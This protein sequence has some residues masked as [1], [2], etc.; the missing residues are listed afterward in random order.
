MACLCMA[1]LGTGT[2]PAAPT[3]VPK[4]HTSSHVGLGHA[5][6]AGA[7]AAKRA[8]RL[9]HQPDGCHASLGCCDRLDRQPGRPAALVYVQRRGPGRRLLVCRPTC[10]PLKA[11]PSPPTRA[12]QRTRIPLDT[13]DRA[14]GARALAGR[15][16]AGPTLRTTHCAAGATGMLLQVIESDCGMPTAL[17][18][19]S[20]QY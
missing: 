9:R 14:R 18:L 15:G 3:T 1:W 20:V 11:P 10:R 12:L 16:A 4:T 7:A 19:H 2:A 8:R 13:R 6:R 5:V 17:R